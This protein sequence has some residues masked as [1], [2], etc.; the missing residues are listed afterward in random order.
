MSVSTVLVMTEGGEHLASRKFPHSS[1]WSPGHMKP[2]KSIKETLTPSWPQKT[3][4]ELEILSAFLSLLDKSFLLSLFYKIFKLPN[5]LTH[6]GMLY[7]L[8]LFF[9]FLKKEEELFR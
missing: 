4:E 5:I 3:T 9:F 2:W 7:L 6:P 8:N 1:H